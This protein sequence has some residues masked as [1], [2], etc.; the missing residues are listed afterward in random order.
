MERLQQLATHTIAA[1]SG[2]QRPLHPLDP[3]SAQEIKEVSTI[4][5]QQYSGKKLNFNTITLREPS[6]KRT[7]TGRKP[8]VQSLLV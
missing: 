1:S 4:I 8:T 7:I 6:K 3:L 5:K 2:P